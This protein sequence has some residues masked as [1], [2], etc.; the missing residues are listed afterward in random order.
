MA[1]VTGSSNSLADLLAAIQSACTT[2]GWT[3]SGNVLHK[4]AC[5]TELVVSSGMITIRGGTGID[6]GNAL[7]GASNAGY[8]YLGWSSTAGPYGVTLAFTWPVTY[9]VHLNTSPDEVYVIVRHDGAGYQSLA[10]GLSNMPGLVGSGGWYA[11]GYYQ[12]DARFGYGN[13]PITPQGEGLVGSASASLFC[14]NNAVH[15]VNHSLDATTWVDA[16]AWRDWGSVAFRQPNQWNAES[17]LMP[18]RVYAA[19]PSGFVS[20]VL[21]C[22]HAR[23]VNIANMADEQVITIGTDKWKVYPW[24]LRSTTASNGSWYC[25]HAFRY[26]GP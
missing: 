18:I 26:D 14:N 7:T 8:G 13:S 12:A 9:F 4:G 21:E 2:N 1:Y 24:F 5:Y 10:F 11:G 3:L 17:L 19:R 23:Y 20:P 16:A 22:A 15:G 25:G 6:G